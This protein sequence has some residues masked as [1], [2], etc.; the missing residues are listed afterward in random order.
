MSAMKIEKVQP[1]L[2]IHDDVC[3]F[4]QQIDFDRVNHKCSK[5]EIDENRGKAVEADSNQHVWG[6]QRLGAEE[7][8]RI[9]PH[10]SIEP[11]FLGR[12]NNQI[13]EWQFDGDAG[14]H[15]PKIYYMHP[16]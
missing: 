1:D 8:F 10:E 14:L 6:V 11:S 4:E 3:H 2:L 5:K 15:H 12:R 13:M 16:R 7:K 9:E